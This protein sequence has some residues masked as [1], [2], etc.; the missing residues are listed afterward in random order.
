MC[1]RCFALENGKIVWWGRGIKGKVT[2]QRRDSATGSGVGGVYKYLAGMEMGVHRGALWFSWRKS[3]PGGLT[4][5]RLPGEGHGG[6]AGLFWRV[7][8]AC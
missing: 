6:E 8:R 4:V 2:G 7:V 1:S 3:R 5:S